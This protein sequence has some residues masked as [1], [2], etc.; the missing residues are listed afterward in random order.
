MRRYLVSGWVL[1][2]RLGIKLYFGSMVMW[3]VG[4]FVYRLFSRLFKLRVLSKK[5][6]SV[7]ECY[8]GLGNDVSLEPSMSSF[9]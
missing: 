5:E 1:E 3:G 9:P 8:I 6:S 7:K 4:P 2:S